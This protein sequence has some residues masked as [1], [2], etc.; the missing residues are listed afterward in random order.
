VLY[1]LLHLGGFSGDLN[2]YATRCSGASRVLELGCGD[3]RVAAALVLGES[4]L[5]VMQQQLQPSTAA[6]IEKEPG[7]MQYVGI[8]LSESLVSKARARLAAVGPRARVVQGDFHSPIDE[9]EFDAII[10][11]ANTL[12]CT[13]RHA[14]VLGRCAEAL[15]TDGLLLLD[16]YNALEWHE[17]A[18]ARVAK[19]EDDTSDT[20]S[21]DCDDASADDDH[22]LLVVVE[23]ESGTEWKVFEREPTVD[24]S[25]QRIACHY[26]FESSGNRFSQTVEHHYAL[27][28]QLVRLVDTAGFE[29][30]AV[31]GGFEGQPFD[32]IESEHVVVVAKRK[33][34]A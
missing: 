11:S 5:S 33:K 23:D 30:E 8:D 6:P 12:F 14:D 7:E 17:E 2:F 31:D 4:S 24:G 25:A 29:I 15:N 3:G 20:A 13:P 32:P 1:S 19:D 18:E 9:G 34:G 22:D 26:D 27:P 28:E 21:T 10:L 16:V